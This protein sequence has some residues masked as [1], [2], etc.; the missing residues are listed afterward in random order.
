MLIELGVP[1]S[2]PLSLVKIDH[3]EGTKTALLSLT[4]GKI[5]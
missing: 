2:L 3:E 1:G 4:N 5:A